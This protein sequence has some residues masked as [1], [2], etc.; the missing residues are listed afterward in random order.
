MGQNFTAKGS[1]DMTQ[2]IPQ[3]LPEHPSLKIVAW[4]YEGAE[5]ALDSFIDSPPETMRLT[6]AKSKSVE[7]LVK[8]SDALAALAA[9]PP[10]GVIPERQPRAWILHTAEGDSLVDYPAEL[11]G[12]KTP[13]TPLYPAIALAEPSI[14]AVESEVGKGHAAWDCVDPKEL[15]TAVVRLAAPQPQ[16]V[17]QD[18]PELGMSMFASMEDFHKAKD[19]DFQ[20]SQDF[21]KSAVVGG[22][23]AA[24]GAANELR[25]AAREFHNLTQGDPEVLIRPPSAAKR[26][27]IQASGERLRAA[28]A[29]TKPGLESFIGES[30]GADFEH[31]TWT[32]EMQ[33][34][35][36]VGAG[37]SSV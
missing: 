35:Y 30:A 1:T 11:Y 23:A 12:S 18:G 15:I 32:F 34:G 36:S 26:D 19:A 28:I 5:G 9:Q 25:E 13:R 37:F 4:M 6:A 8:L 14:E 10:V 31:D 27:A 16:A 33:P 2:S 29:A 21:I 17:Q 24:Q 20:S 22:D 3:T 7:P